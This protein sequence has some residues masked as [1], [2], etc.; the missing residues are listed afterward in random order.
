MNHALLFW[1][2][3]TLFAL[4][5]TA[6]AIVLRWSPRWLPSAEHWMSGRVPY[7]YLLPWQLSLL[8]GMIWTACSLTTGDGLFVRAVWQDWAHVFHWW[9]L[10]YFWAMPCRY[11]LTMV[12]HPER[13][14][15]KRTIPI[16]FHM[17][18]ACAWYVFADYHGA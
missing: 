10:L 2:A 4:R 18:L 11:V 9:A 12:Q 16:W 3:T 14:W 7:R 15:F 1:I 5:V 6:Q 17:I 8:L 13:R